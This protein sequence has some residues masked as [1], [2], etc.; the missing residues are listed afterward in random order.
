MFLMIKYV[1]K[2]SIPPTNKRTGTANMANTIEIGYDLSVSPRFN[3]IL[4][5]ALLLIILIHMIKSSNISMK[6][7][8]KNR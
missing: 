2:N 4:L 8:S 3:L 6:S 5:R 7:D 1:W